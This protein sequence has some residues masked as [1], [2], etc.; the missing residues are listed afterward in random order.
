M[1]MK[2]S[3][4]LGTE[5]QVDFFSDLNIWFDSSKQFH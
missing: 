2:N 4:A 3:M 1:L 5:P